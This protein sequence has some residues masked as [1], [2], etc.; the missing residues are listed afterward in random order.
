MPKN[1]KT[2]IF[3]NEIHEFFNK[4]LTQEIQKRLSRGK[5][6]SNDLIQMIIECSRESELEAE[7]ITEQF[8]IF[9]TGGYF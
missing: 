1:F 6:E 5:T 3:R 8:L 7:A 9:F 2:K 4:N